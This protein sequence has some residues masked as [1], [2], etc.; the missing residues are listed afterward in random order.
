MHAKE[1]DKSDI[2]KR[3]KTYCFV[4]SK[5][6]SQMLFIWKRTES[7][8]KHIQNAHKT[9]LN[10]NRRFAQAIVPVEISNVAPEITLNISDE[11]KSES[12]RREE[13]VK[14]NVT[15]PEI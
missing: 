6:S 11:V 5:H 12:Q 14:K 13:T 15:N 9:K 8:G 4:T 10:G 2:H 7:D 3:V 1:A